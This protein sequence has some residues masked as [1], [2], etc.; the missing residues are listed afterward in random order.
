M[1][2]ALIVRVRCRIVALLVRVH[3]KV[4]RSKLLAVGAVKL[5]LQNSAIRIQRRIMMR[6][7]VYQVFELACAIPRVFDVARIGISTIRELYNN[8]IRIL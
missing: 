8:I 2:L 4:S 3:W 6:S 1:L 7:R 5:A